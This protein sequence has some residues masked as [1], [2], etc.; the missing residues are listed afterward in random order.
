MPDPLP[1]RILLVLQLH[2][3]GE[4]LLP[5][6]KTLNLFGIWKEYIPFIPLFLSPQTTS[7]S[8]HFYDDY[9]DGTAIASA[10][11]TLPRFC[12][13]LQRVYLH[14]KS[15]DPIIAAAVSGM[16]LAL[17]RKT[18][19]KFKVHSTLTDEGRE[20]FRDLPDLR[21]LRMNIYG[22][23]SLP[24]L[25]LPNLTSLC[26]QYD[27]NH[28]WLEGFRGAT[29]GKLTSISFYFYPYC[30]NQ[31]TV[32]NLLETFESVALTTSIPATLSEF[33]FTTALRWKP[34][35][36]SLL[37]FTQLKELSL[38]FGCFPSGH[39]CSCALDDDTITDLAR[40]MPKLEVLKSVRF[41]CWTPTGV[42]TRGL[43]ALARYCPRLSSLSIHLQVS[44]LDP[45]KIPQAASGDQFNIPPAG[46]ALT[47]INVGMIALPEELVSKVIQTLLQIF[48]RLG[49]IKHMKE[50][51][52]KVADVLNVSGQLADHSGKRLLLGK[53][54]NNVVDDPPAGIVLEDV[55][56]R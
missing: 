8:L 45:S 40:A 22:S 42:T 30:Y 34:N 17:N 13:S 15:R 31:A 52:E 53:S 3:C 19:Q 50:G 37:P 10:I 27:N 14:P 9:Y 7:I 5:N 33:K 18:L 12:P 28:G 21:E 38:D 20:A 32:G 41:P 24:T 16:L 49:R 1:L 26:I 6:L 56:Q 36:R 29:F 47:C 2:L 44:S 39:D 23:S 43:A 55:T 51:W 54:H 25:G 4:P 35:Y 46:C 11:I 48:P